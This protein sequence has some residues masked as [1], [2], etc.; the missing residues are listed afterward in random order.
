MRTDWFKDA[1]N[2]LPCV[3]GG[4]PRSGGRIVKE[5]RKTR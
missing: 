3:K 2:S 1:G 5:R 4:G